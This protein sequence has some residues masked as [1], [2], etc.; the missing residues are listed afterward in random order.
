MIAAKPPEPH[1]VRGTAS[2]NTQVAKLV[3]PLIVMKPAALVVLIGALMDVVA[4][5]DA[6]ILAILQ[7]ALLPVDMAPAVAQAHQ[8]ALLLAQ[9]V[10]DQ[11]KNGAVSVKK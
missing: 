3:A 10:Q 4:H 5:V 6:A 1:L 11:V 7:V 8:V 2:L 9:E